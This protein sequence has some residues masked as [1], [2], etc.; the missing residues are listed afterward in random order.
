MPPKRP[1]SHRNADLS[2]SHVHRVFESVGWTVED[3]DKD[4][5]E[6]LLVRIF[7]NDEVTPYAFFIQVKST[8]QIEKYLTRDGRYVR[9]P[10]TSGHVDHWAKFSELVLVVV[11]DA[12]RDIAYW[13]T[14]QSPERPTERMSPRW[15]YLYLPRD[16]VLDETGTRRILA[17][18]KRRHSR[19]DAE[20]DGSQALIAAIHALGGTVDEYSPD[21]L[22]AVKGIVPEYVDVTLFGDI[23]EGFEAAKSRLELSDEE[24]MEKILHDLISTIDMFCESGGVTIGDRKFETLPEFLQFLNHH[25]DTPEHLSDFSQFLER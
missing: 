18:T 12:V 17:R 9:Y 10:L 14:V 15:S 25:F 3:L 1:R 16:N 19:L 24:L 5:G 2:V 20:K 22:L 13:E 4:Y 7:Q 21:G 6:D 11:W 8:V 23:L